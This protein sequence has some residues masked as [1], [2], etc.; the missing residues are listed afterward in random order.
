MRPILCASVLVALAII[1]PCARAQEAA[2]LVLVNAVIHTMDPERPSAS[3][4]AALDGRI[5]AVGE[6]EDVLAAHRGPETEVL[7]A[8][9]AT[10]L[11]GLID[12]HGHVM[13]LGR[14][15]MTV[16]LFGTRSA[17]EVAERVRDA[18]RSRRAGE[19][20][21]GRGWDQNDWAVEEFPTRALLDRA[22]PGQAWG[23]AFA[24][25]GLGGVI[26]TACALLLPG[27]S[28]APS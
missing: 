13:N 22:A 3:A 17:E 25:M 21:L 26:A 19:W 8:A 6:A 24:L 7:D 1:A 14:F 2:D 27:T 18:A 5:V 4:L 9:G 23:W 10:V 16:D 20:I 11:P 12:A 28:R 15:L